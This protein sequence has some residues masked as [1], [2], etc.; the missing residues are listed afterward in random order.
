LPLNIGAKKAGE[1][2]KFPWEI[3]Q[4]SQLCKTENKFIPTECSKNLKV[5]I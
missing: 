3:T 2:K 4:R 5:K 1:E